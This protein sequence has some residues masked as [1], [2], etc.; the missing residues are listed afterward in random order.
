MNHYGQLPAVNISFNLRP[1][2]A[3][4]TAVD[5]MEQATRDIGLPQTTA[6]TFQEQP[7]L[8]RIHLRVLE[9]CL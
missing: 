6:L 7:P 9:F 4:G 1:G 5:Q 3:L 2:A 8:F